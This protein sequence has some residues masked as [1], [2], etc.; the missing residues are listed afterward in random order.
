LPS[1]SVQPIR[2]GRGEG[3]ALLC[4]ICMIFQS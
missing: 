2:S 1:P 3:A 4:T